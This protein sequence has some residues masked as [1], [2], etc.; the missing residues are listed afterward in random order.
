MIIIG[1]IIVA[2]IMSILALSATV[3]FIFW[4]LQ[5][6]WETWA[7]WRYAAVATFVGVGS[8]AR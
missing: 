5:W 8:R 6:F 4:D 1:Y 2:V 3:S 7:G